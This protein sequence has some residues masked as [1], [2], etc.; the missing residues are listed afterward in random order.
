MNNAIRAGVVMLGALA[1]LPAQAGGVIGAGV[2]YADDLRHDNYSGFKSQGALGG[3]FYAGYRFERLPLMAE[4]SYLDMGQ[5]RLTDASDG[6]HVGSF[7]F[8]GVNASV[9]VPLHLGPVVTWLKGGYYNGDS[10]LRVDGFAAPLGDGIE[11]RFTRK[12]TGASAGLGADLM[13]TSVLGLR[14]DYQVLFEAHDFTGGDGKGKSHL[15]LASVGLTL[16]FGSDGAR[17][18]PAAVYSST[19]MPA[20]AAPVPMTVSVPVK[21]PAVLAGTVI[22]AR[23]TLDAGASATLVSE[24]PV[25]L[26]SKTENSTGTWWYVKAGDVQGWVQDAQVHQ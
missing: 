7:G 10:D 2:G 14:F 5:H 23:P 19:G 6:S 8:K 1:C 11:T 15:S 24:T 17:S 13:L 22:R 25:Q 20:A 16:A 4:L 18:A 21:G 3:T 12:S 26:V 9:G